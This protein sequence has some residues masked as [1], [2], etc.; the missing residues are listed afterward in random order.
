MAINDN[1]LRPSKAEIL[2][3]E[4]QSKILESRYLS[5]ENLQHL[6]L[7]YYD[8]FKEKKLDSADLIFNSFTSPKHI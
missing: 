1:F 8:I 4:L 5:P 2:F 6:F 7:D 3:M